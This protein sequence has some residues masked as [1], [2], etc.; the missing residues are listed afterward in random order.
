MNYINDD[1]I[2]EI[3]YSLNSIID[4]IQFKLVNKKI[5]YLYNSLNWNK[6]NKLHNL[7]NLK[8][9][10]INIFH[11]P[12]SFNYQLLIGYYDEIYTTMS[13]Y[14][15]K[16]LYYYIKYNKKIPTM[17]FEFYYI[18]LSY[19]TCYNIYKDKNADTS[20]ILYDI[21]NYSIP[22]VDT[23]KFIEDISHQH[24]LYIIPKNRIDLTGG[25]SFDYVGEKIIENNLIQINLLFSDNSMV[26]IQYSKI[27]TI[28]NIKIQDDDETNVIITN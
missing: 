10:D 7:H 2:M 16:S 18:P 12:L 17:K 26:S 6:I 8:N 21:S 25:Y 15:T 13:M 3:I 5:L 28:D 11:R 9:K 27:L 19:N 22:L 23:L 20:I 1:M 24:Q 14:Y 4:I